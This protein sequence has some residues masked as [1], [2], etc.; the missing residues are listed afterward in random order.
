MG[1]RNWD[2]V[3]ID[4]YTADMAEQA[5]MAAAIIERLTQE[6]VK[7]ERML[8]CVVASCKDGSISV[9]RGM[10]VFDEQISLETLH[11]IDDDMLILIAKRSPPKGTS[12]PCSPAVPEAQPETSGNPTGTGKPSPQT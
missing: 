3:T 11:R 8:K 5:K 1:V 10:F 6:K 2:Y 12:A 4:D 7:A 9:P